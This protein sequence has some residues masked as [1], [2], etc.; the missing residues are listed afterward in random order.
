MFEGRAE[1]FSLTRRHNAGN[2]DD[3]SSMQWFSPMESEEV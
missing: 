2:N 3:H 1:E